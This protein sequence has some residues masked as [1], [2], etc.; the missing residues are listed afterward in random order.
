MSVLPAS[1]ALAVISNHL[2]C[3]FVEIGSLGYPSITTVRCLR[4]VHARWRLAIGSSSEAI[5]VVT[6]HEIFRLSPF[7]L[8]KQWEHALECLDGDV[9][10]KDQGL[11]FAL[12]VLL[13][14]EN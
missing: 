3:E 1:L 11:I 8:A 7:E 4:P 10:V 9:H 13:G 12:A 14:Q 5:N 6:K 2:H